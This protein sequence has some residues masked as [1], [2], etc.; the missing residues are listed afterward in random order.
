MYNMHTNMHTEMHVC[1][2]VTKLTPVTNQ[3]IT[4]LELGGESVLDETEITVET[5]LRR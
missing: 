4:H 3:D 5:H 1:I 2:Y